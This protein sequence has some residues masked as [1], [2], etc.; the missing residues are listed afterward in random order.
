MSANAPAGS[1][2]I[3][4]GSVVAASTK[5]TIMGDG[6]SEVINHAAPTSCIHVPMFEATEAI[7]SARNRGCCKGLHADLNDGLLIDTKVSN[8]R[9]SLLQ[10]EIYVNQ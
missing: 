1:A 7:Q 3:N 5:A 2:S 6:A 8:Q 9:L 10:G 4:I